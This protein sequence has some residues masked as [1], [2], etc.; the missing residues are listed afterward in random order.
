MEWMQDN[1]E[2]LSALA[3]ILMT[4]A[5][6]TYAQFA[7]VTYFRQRRPRIVI[8]Q[9][10]DHSLDTRFV[11]VNLSE[12]PV[13]ISGIMVCVRR[14]DDQ[15]FH[16]IDRFQ[17]SSSGDDD[18]DAGSPSTEDIEAQL[19]HGTLDVG[20]L[21]LIGSSKE[22]LSWLLEDGDDDADQP[23]DNRLRGAL[24]EID[25]FEFRVVAMAGTDDHSVASARTFHIE[26]EN[27]EIRIVPL[28]S[29]TRHYASWRHRH[30]ADK[31]SEQLRKM[32][33]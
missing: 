24:A 29:S 21:F 25:D 33:A 26:Y 18:E 4:I 5:W 32:H 11:I 9:T 1:A 22:T 19:R 30:I 10:A 14:G 3:T 12:L 16:K 27:D 7:I 28:D 23:F 8:D 20:Q 17:R 31:W 13:Y 15:T 6:V 2:L